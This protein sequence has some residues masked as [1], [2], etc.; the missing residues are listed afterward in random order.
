MGKLDVRNKGRDGIGS[1]LTMPRRDITRL[2]VAL[3]LFWHPL[4]SCC[5]QELS[6]CCNSNRNQGLV[7]SCY[8]L[9]VLATPDFNHVLMFVALVVLL[10]PSILDHSAEELE[11]SGGVNAYR[12][13]M[14]QD[15]SVER[16]SDA[17]LTL[18]LTTNRK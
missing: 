13:R 14:R 5:L 15:K 2:S 8:V 9:F 16:S 10:V 4:D 18:G 12:E 3:N 17:M 7:W 6:S 1:Q 11:E